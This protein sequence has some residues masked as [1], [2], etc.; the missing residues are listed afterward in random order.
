MKLMRILSLMI[1]SFLISYVFTFQAYAESVLEYADSAFMNQIKTEFYQTYAGTLNRGKDAFDTNGDFNQAE[2]GEGI[3]FYQISENHSLEQMGYAFPLE[4]QGRTVATIKAIPGEEGSQIIDVNS[5]AD[6]TEQINK[7]KQQASIGDS[8]KYIE[9]DRYQARGFYIQNESEENFVDL[10]K[11]V[12]YPMNE[13]YEAADVIKTQRSH[14]QQRSMRG[15]DIVQAGGGAG[16]EMRNSN[17]VLVP[18][19]LAGAGI[20]VGVIGLVIALKMKRNRTN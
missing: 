10:N 2:L 11:G 8:I 6:L 3:A 4:V 12:I 20:V 14:D 7:V 18:S 15:T 16:E 17:S 1:S 13:L 9:D 5:S 19:V